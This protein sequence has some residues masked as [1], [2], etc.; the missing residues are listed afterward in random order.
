[1][2]NFYDFDANKIESCHI[3][4]N[5]LFK[6]SEYWGNDIA[7]IILHEIQRIL[8]ITNNADL[9][10][11]ILYMKIREQLTN[12]IAYILKNHNKLDFTTLKTFYKETRF[13]EDCFFEQLK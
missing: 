13:Q 6:A 8:F 12:F 11:K 7:N 5:F 10:E 2:A 9:D 4:D 1:M 3:M